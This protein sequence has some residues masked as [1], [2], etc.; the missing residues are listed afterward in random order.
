MVRS[1]VGA[2]LPVGDG[3]RRVGWP[4]DILTGRRREPDADVAPAI[5]LCLE[6]VEYPPDADLAEQ[7]RRARRFRGPDSG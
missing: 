2:L 7:A 6:H 1:I 4:A 3:R 5:G